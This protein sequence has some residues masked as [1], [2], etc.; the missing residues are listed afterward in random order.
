MKLRDPM[1][2]SEK[3]LKILQ[4]FTTINQSLSF[5]E[6]N[7]I[8]TIS[9]MKNVL[10]EAEIEEYIPK[11]FAI[12]DLPQFLNTLAL[13][14]DPDI[15][16]SSNPSF[17]HIKSG[18]HSRSKYFFS[19]PSVIIAPPEKEMILPSE[20]VSFILQEDQ[21][22]KMLKSASI[23]QL[24]DLAVVGDEGVV[25]TVVSD[26]KND[27]S[28]ESAIVVGQTDKTFSFNFKIEN[29]KLIPGSYQV[30]ISSKNLAR[31]YNSSYKLT[32]FIA[33]EP[34]SNYDG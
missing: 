31:F 11:D 22:A 19:D 16:V 8:R 9:V 2:L 17:A 12:Y 21:L 6:G 20:D 23:L 32:Y 26:R 13:Y 33:L 18:T 27:T 5:K 28:N 4:N 14:R 29:I 1:R 24:P 30:T 3:T 15:D 7:K 10:A 34:D 25:K